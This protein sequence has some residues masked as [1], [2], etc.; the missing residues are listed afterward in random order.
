MEAFFVRDGTRLLATDRT[1]GPWTNE[2]QHGGPPAA[3]LTGAIERAGLD[4]AEFRLARVTVEFL[5]PVP[6]A[7]LEVSAEVVRPAGRCSG[8]V[9]RS[10]RR[11]WRWRGRLECACAG[12]D[13]MCPAAGVLSSCHTRTR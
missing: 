4:A 1:R 8:S 2:H 7:A 13:W 9:L 12:S 10:L 3:L 5:R 6:V 11:A